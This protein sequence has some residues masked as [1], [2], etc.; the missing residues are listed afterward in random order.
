MSACTTY[1]PSHDPGKGKATSEL[2]LKQS[3]KTLKD[4]ETK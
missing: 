2:N 4:I 1:I 3:L